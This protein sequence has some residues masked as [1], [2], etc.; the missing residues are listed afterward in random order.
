MK[1]RDMLILIGSI[2]IAVGL[3]IFFKD[4]RLYSFGFFRFGAVSTGGILIVLLLLDVILLVAV[5]HKAFKILLPILIGCLV[6]S[7]ILGSHITFSDSVLNLLLSLIPAAVGA[8]LILKAVFLKK[9][10]K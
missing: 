4:A 2:L 3:F 7:I 9:E 8:G 10:E 5:R 1:K 6:L